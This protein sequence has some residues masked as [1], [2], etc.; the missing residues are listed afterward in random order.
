[1]LQA[2]RP[3]R[4]WHA[5]LAAAVSRVVRSAVKGAQFPAPP[6]EDRV[7]VV[8]PGPQ[9]LPH[10][11]IGLG[12]KRSPWA[13]DAAEDSPRHTAGAC[14]GSCWAEAVELAETTANRQLATTRVL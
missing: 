12:R 4:F 11:L 2:L 5:A 13:R 8:P 9:I 10:L 14:S 6:R 7:E 1:M 3:V